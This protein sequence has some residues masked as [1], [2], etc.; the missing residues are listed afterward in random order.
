MAVILCNFRRLW[1]R[2]FL[3]ESGVDAR[4]LV[5]L[6]TTVRTAITSNLNF[7]IGVRCVSPLRIVSGIST[8]CTTV[9]SWLFVVLVSTKRGRLFIVRLFLARWCVRSFVPPELG[10]QPLVFLSKVLVFFLKRDQ[11]LKDFFLGR[12][13]R[14]HRQARRDGLPSEDHPSE[15]HSLA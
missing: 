13:R 11:T 1:I 15:A 6:L 3:N 5:E 12:L 2:E 14:G 10:S 8:R 7:L 9:S 4:R